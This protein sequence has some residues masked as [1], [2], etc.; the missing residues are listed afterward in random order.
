VSRLAVLRRSAVLGLVCAAAL[1]ADAGMAWAHVVAEPSAATQ[2]SY[3]VVSF[4][5]PN[6]KNTATTVR[7]QVTLPAD[8][9][10]ASVAVEPVPGWTATMDKTT[11]THPLRT[12]DGAVSQAVSTIT[13][14][15]GQIAPDQFQEFRVSLGPL[16]RDTDRLVFKAV[17]TYSNG[18]VVR[19]IDVPGPGDPEPEHL[20][21]V[22]RLTPATDGA[23]TGLA[24]PAGWL[25]V[26]GVV[27][28]LA[29]VLLGGLALRRRAG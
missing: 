15:G 3:A 9:P 5:T 18:D 24:G 26:A 27:L 2:G 8:H 1:L 17:Q 12:G 14:S 13:W 22:L 7:L 23:A 10:I 29:G 16:P 20:A 25:G 11:L 4:R 21:P 6:E 19:W 28:G